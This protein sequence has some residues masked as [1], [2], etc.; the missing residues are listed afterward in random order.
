MK[1]S[2]NND[3]YDCCDVTGLYPG[4]KTVGTY[5]AKDNYDCCDITGLYVKDCGTLMYMA[6]PYMLTLHFNCQHCTFG[7][8]TPY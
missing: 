2:V 1:P 5:A 8:L 7:V 3:F 4:K 6:S